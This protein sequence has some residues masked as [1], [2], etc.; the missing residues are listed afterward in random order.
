[1]GSVRIICLAGALAAAVI[2]SGGAALA[3]EKEQCFLRAGYFAFPLR[4]LFGRGPRILYSLSVLFKDRNF[5]AAAELMRKEGI[6]PPGKTENRVHVI[7][8]SFVLWDPSEIR[9]AKKKYWFFRFLER[10]GIYYQARRAVYC[11]P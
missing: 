2:L 6:K 4:H 7:P 8:A 11:K 5:A 3:E 10:D 1:M 9:V